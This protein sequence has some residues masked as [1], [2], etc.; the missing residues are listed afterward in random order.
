MTKASQ[1]D[2]VVLDWVPCICYPIRSKKNEIQALI[3]SGSKLN[4]MTQGYASKLGLK[5]RPT[6][7]EA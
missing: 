2:V 1:E 7:G 5:V 6:D 3:D 4:A